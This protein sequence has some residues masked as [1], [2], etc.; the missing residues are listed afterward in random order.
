MTALDYAVVFKNHHHEQI[1]RQAM[2]AQNI[3]PHTTSE[4][5][6]FSGT[7]SIP[8]PVAKP[9]EDAADDEKEEAR[10][11]GDGDGDG[12]DSWRKISSKKSF[13][14]RFFSKMRK[15]WDFKFCFFI[16]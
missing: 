6:K 10:G 14:L 8:I 15:S 2:V 7:H 9:D 16:N 1:L 11:D 12:A 3:L 13:V 4:D 5:R